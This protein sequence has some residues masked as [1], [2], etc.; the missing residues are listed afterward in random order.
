LISIFGDVGEMLKF[1]SLCHL[2]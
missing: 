1:I 2:I